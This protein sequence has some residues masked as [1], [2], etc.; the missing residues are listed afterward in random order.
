MQKELEYLS[1]AVSNPAH[2]YVAILGGSKISGKIDV[3]KN[4]LR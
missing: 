2:P 3:I 1:K 4:L